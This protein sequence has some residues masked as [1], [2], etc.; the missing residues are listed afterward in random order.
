VRSATLRAGVLK[1]SGV[2]GLLRPGDAALPVLQ[3]SSTPDGKGG[4]C[5]RLR[6]PLGWLSAA[7]PDGTAIVNCWGPAGVEE[8]PPTTQDSSPG[9]K[10]GPGPG[11][12]AA[13]PEEMLLRLLAGAAGGGGAAGSESPLA[14]LERQL[15]ETAPLRTTTAEREE[16]LRDPAPPGG[17]P[18]LSSSIED[19]EIDRI[20][21]S[22]FDEVRC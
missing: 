1:T 19:M 16:L 12:P 8:I 15:G 22:A 14:S 2:L 20:V 10:L 6:T 18:P 5:K 21:A 9:L 3:R 7:A 4:W 11:A 17:P 13:S